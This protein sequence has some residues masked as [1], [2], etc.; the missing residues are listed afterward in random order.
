VNDLADHQVNDLA[1]HL[2]NDLANLADHPANH[3]VQFA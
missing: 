3:L 2:V 1:G